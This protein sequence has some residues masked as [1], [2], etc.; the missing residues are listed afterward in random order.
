[1]GNNVLNEDQQARAAVLECSLFNQLSADR[2][3]QLLARSRLVEM[4]E[5]EYLVQQGAAASE[6]FLVLSVEI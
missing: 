2:V 4:E 1:M 6:F 5:G 3:D